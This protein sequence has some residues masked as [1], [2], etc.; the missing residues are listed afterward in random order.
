MA[1]SS[2]SEGSRVGPGGERGRAHG[3]R[4]EVGVGIHLVVVLS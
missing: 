1:S 3:Q 4:M 2:S